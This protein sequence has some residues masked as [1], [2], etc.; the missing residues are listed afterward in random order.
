MSPSYHKTGALLLLDNSLAINVVKRNVPQPNECALSDNYQ[1]RGGGVVCGGGT[2]WKEA[3]PHSVIGGS[4]PYILS[5]CTSVFMR[6][7]INALRVKLPF[8]GTVCV[9]WSWIFFFY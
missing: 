6:T 3:P 9:W 1:R 8:I 7:H 2:E 5:F 4:V